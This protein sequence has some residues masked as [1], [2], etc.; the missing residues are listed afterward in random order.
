[1]LTNEQAPF[2]YRLTGPIPPTE[3]GITLAVAVT[4]LAVGSAGL[5]LAPHRRRSSAPNLVAPNHDHYF[6]FRIDF[7]IESRTLVLNRQK[8]PQVL[9]SRSRTTDAEEAEVRAVLG[10][11]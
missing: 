3:L 10:G 1:M 7:D 11:G 2:D 6:N 5:A 9:R 4:T 8:N